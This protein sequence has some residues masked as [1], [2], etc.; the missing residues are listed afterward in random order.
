MSFYVAALTVSQFEA[1]EIGEVSK[2]APAP[3]ASE[4]FSFEAL[5][6]MPCIEERISTA[7]R[8]L[9][10]VQRPMLTTMQADG[11]SALR[12]RSREQNSS[13][14][15]SHD[16]QSGEESIFQASFQLS[17]SLC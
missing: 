15:I 12:L 4:G 6:D 11:L 14:A 17:A 9:V 5:V 3:N 13:A 16:E 7:V 8:V 1:R 2:P 10:C